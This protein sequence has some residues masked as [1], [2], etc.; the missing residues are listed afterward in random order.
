MNDFN[1]EGNVVECNE[2]EGN[3]VVKFVKFSLRG[4]SKLPKDTA[5][6][7]VLAGHSCT[8]AKD[9]K[10]MA[11]QTPLSVCAAQPCTYFQ[12]TKQLI[13]CIAYTHCCA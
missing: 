12:H 5:I 3:E 10:S 4:N 13:G 6:F 9:C 8:G 11:I 1:F 2:A 7:S